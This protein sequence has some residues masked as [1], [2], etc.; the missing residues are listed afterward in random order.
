V[1]E[2]FIVGVVR[3]GAR[4]GACFSPRA[5]SGCELHSEAEELVEEIK[6]GIEVGQDRLVSGASAS[7]HLVAHDI[8]LC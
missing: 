7:H 1:V 3:N 4:A 2:G 8:D 6:N 5:E